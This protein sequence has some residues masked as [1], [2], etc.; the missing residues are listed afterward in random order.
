MKEQKIVPI[1]LGILDLLL[2]IGGIAWTVYSMNYVAPPV[3][4]ELE[5]IIIHAFT[6][7]VLLVELSYGITGYKKSSSLFFSITVFLYAAL[8]MSNTLLVRQGPFFLPLLSIIS[9]GTLCVLAFAKDLGK[10][11]SYAFCLINL[12]SS[13]IRIVLYKVVAG[14]VLGAMFGNLLLAITLCIMIYAKYAD[15]AAR[16]TK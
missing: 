12:A 10:K 9:F 13:V 3:G 5:Y 11:K 6:L 1:W 2:I 4:Y 7:V 16:G 8:A 14:T 15:K